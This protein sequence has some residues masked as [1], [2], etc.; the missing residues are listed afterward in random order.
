MRCSI[1]MGWDC[2]SGWEGGLAFIFGAVGEM[3]MPTTVLAWDGTLSHG[4][5]W[6]HLKKKCHEIVD[7]YLFSEKTRQY[8]YLGPL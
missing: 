7:P 8:R 1:G 4:M 2:P 6:N 3:L 5:G